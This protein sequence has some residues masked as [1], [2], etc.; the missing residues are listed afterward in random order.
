MER[1]DNMPLWAY[2]ALLGIKS[3]KV[4]MIFFIATFILSLVAT[5]VGVIIED[6]SLAALLFVPLWYW[7]S[8]KWVDV[9]SSWSASENSE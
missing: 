6:Y 2:W 9:Y 3:R 8:I 5:A 7:I 4:A 1:K